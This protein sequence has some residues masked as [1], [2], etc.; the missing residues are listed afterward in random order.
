MAI[1]GVCPARM[2]NFKVIA[3]S[4]ALKVLAEDD[5]FQDLPPNWQNIIGKIQEKLTHRLQNARF[6]EQLSELT[7]RAPEDD[8]KAA[9]PEAVR[10]LIAALNNSTMP[11]ATERADLKLEFARNYTPRALNSKMPRQQ[12]K[13]C[14]EEEQR[15]EERSRHRLIPGLVN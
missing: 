11:N 10:H 3:S 5:F 6:S 4:E 14:R 2:E 15:P 7:Q 8:I 1:A 12:P 13:N 9:L